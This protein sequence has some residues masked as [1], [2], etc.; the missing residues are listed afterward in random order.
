MRIFLEGVPDDI[1]TALYVAKYDTGENPENTLQYNQRKGITNQ[2][3]AEMIKVEY[4]NFQLFQLDKAQ[5]TRYE[6]FFGV[7]FAIYAEPGNGRITFYY[8][9]NSWQN[10]IFLRQHTRK[11]KGNFII[12]YTLY[13]VL[14]IIHYTF[15][16]IIIISGETV[17]QISYVKMNVRDILPKLTKEDSVMNMPLKDIFTLYG[18]VSPDV[19]LMDKSHD[20]LEKFTNCHIRVYQLI[21]GEIKHGES[22]ISVSFPEDYQDHQIHLLAKD[23]NAFLEVCIIQ[24]TLYNIHCTIYII[25]RIRHYYIIPYSGSRIR[26]S[27]DC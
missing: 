26:V 24:Y 21:D 20:E 4:A 7:N 22:Q 25:Q 19:P 5:Y 2:R 27:T 11:I 16:D 13:N 6:E 14:Y 17:I 8:K 9:S 15:H 10:M 12:H 23:P 18:K 1:F 3:I